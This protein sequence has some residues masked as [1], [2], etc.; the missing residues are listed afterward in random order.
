MSLPNSDY[1]V[2]T[3]IQQ[4]LV[5]KDTGAP[6]SGGIIYFWEDVAN[7]IPKDVYV[8][9]Q[10]PGPTYTFTNI[11]SQVTLSSVGTTQYLGTDSIIFLLPFDSSGNT[12][13]YFIS[14]YSS[15]GTFQFSRN[16]WPPNLPGS[17]S[18]AS[19]TQS[20]NIVSNPQFARVLFDSVNGS[21]INVTGSGTVTAIAPDWNVITTGT[22]T[23]TL[24][25]IAVVDPGAPGLPAFALQVQ[26]ASLTGNVILSQTIS[27][28][29][30]L[31]ENGFASGS[32]IAQAGA[33]TTVSMNYVPSNPAMTSVQLATNQVNTGG[34]TV[35]HGTAATPTPAT[36]T[37][38]GLV[39]Y[40]NIQIVIPAGANVT[41]S[42]VQ[43]L[44]VA[45]STVVP[46]YIQESTPR[47]ID[48]LFHYYQPQI[49]FK[50]I[51][52]LLTGW[53]F[54]LN[55]N[56]FGVTSFSTPS[57]YVWDQTIMCSATGTVN[58]S[59]NSSTGALALVTTVD[60]EAFYLLQYLSGA[61]AF[62][63]TLSRLAVNISVFQLT[64]TG[65]S[66]KVFLYQSNSSGSIPTS[67][68][69][70]S[71][72][73][74]ATT[75]VFTLTSANWALIPQLDGAAS[76]AT[77]GT[78]TGVLDFGF[79]LWNG[80]ANFGASTA[81]NF[82]I[83]VT[84]AV[85]TTGTSVNIQSISCVPG[86]IPTRPAPQSVDEVL[87]QCQ[88]YY[89]KS[90]LQGITPAQNAGT[91]SGEFYALQTIDG[92]IIS[93]TTNTFPVRF[94]IPMRTTPT[95]P[96]IFYN[97]V[98]SNA[99]VHNFDTVGDWTTTALKANTLTANGFIITGTAQPSSL[100]GDDIGV[101]YTADA[102][103]GVV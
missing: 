60:T 85:P 56:Q 52:S 75:G 22:G 6:L 36:N 44:G 84:F 74:I 82:A 15:S 67:A 31:L 91:N 88:Y 64:H 57:K 93:G 54:P 80:S 29:P 55:P 23:V 1:F 78:N 76:T 71:I 46:D 92:A 103:L 19:F 24:N 102:R 83:V 4:Y 2:M 26:S 58:V 13:T 38:S 11:G 20:E 97:P 99:F 98:A 30:R 33:L 59:R 101:H 95:N 14:V 45:N 96:P 32:F 81:A 79:N 73:T 25:Q 94:P 48:H 18:S 86:D 66:I 51:P 43:V 10:A 39:G 61:Q 40:I 37:D 62:E 72:G 27:M 7:T 53:D 17:S 34:F 21:T 5:D 9:T 68:T 41:L 3:D 16:N 65:V 87:R 47:Q 50:P 70:A 12:Q 77:M 35:V 90:F 42:C 63:T 100:V 28:S 8:Q 89:Q 49:N 69:G